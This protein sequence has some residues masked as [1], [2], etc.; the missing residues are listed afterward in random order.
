MFSPSNENNSHDFDATAGISGTRYIPSFNPSTHVD[1]KTLLDTLALCDAS[2]MPDIA[3]YEL[4]LPCWG[5]H[6]AR[7]R[8][9]AGAQLIC[10]AD[11]A[12]ALYVVRTGSFKSVVLDA[13][14]VAQIVGFPMRGELLGAQAFADGKYSANVYALE[15][16]DVIV[17]PLAKLA[18]LSRLYPGFEQ[19]IFRG[20]AKSLVREQNQL[21]TLGSQ[22]ATARLAQFLLQL[23]TFYGQTGYATNAFLL[24]M[25]RTEI[26]SYLSLTIETVSRT[27]AILQSAGVID[28]HQRSVKLIDLVR[29]TQF[30]RGGARTSAKDLV[31]A[32][33]KRSAATHP[34]A[35]RLGAKRLG[36][37][38]LLAA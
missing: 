38:Q 17:L 27:F 21:W 15:D 5:E 35:K 6:L 8:I 12:R 14:G 23:A 29:L 7:K 19:I 11:V 32:T 18:E 9:V 4:I 20:M 22:C 30:C 31:K 25:T 33:A 28:I 37:K 34:S 1:V 13:N 26:A 2:A 24:R 16:S 10:E 3:N 36:A